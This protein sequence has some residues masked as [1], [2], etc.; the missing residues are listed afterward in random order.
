[1]IGRFYLPTKRTAWLIAHE[2]QT[3]YFLVFGSILEL[4]PSQMPE[5]YEPKVSMETIIPIET[6][7]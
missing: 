7:P 6:G 5:L 4:L 2:S 3:L 1:M